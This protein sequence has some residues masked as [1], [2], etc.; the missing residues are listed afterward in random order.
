M[1]DITAEHPQP[2]ELGLDTC[3]QR[4][5]Q[6][7]YV[8][9]VPI[10]NLNILGGKEDFGLAVNRSRAQEQLLVVAQIAIALQ[11][12]KALSNSHGLYQQVVH[13]IRALEACQ[14]KKGQGCSAPHLIGNRRDVS[15]GEL[16]SGLMF[17]K[18]GH[19]QGR[20]YASI[21]PSIHQSINQG[22]HYHYSLLK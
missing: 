20:Q 9:V 18:R 5:G 3:I 11:M 1:H 4:K 22:M 17:S 19:I 12:S 14:R 15:T 2:E 13:R 7:E 10:D 8:Q 6:N 21:H 16:R